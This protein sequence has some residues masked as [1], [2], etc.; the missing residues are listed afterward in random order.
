[1]AVKLGFPVA[2]VEA[3]LRSFD[4]TMPE[5][6]NRLLTDAISTWLFVSE[7]SG[8]ANLEREGVD[9]GRVHFVGNVMIDTLM[10]SRARADALGMPARLG[11]QPGEYAVL[12]LH[13]PSNVDD[14]ATLAALLE[15]ILELASRIPVVF[16]VHPRTAAMLD[17]LGV[18]ERVGLRRL[19]PQGY[20]EFLGLLAAARLVVTDSGGIQEETTVLGVPCVTL[21]ENTERPVTITEGTNRLAGVSPDAVRRALADAQTQP[22][23]AYAPELWDGAAAARV[24]ALLAQD[25]AP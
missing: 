1:V 10:R 3:G 6:I 18:G 20:L 16:P 4:R 17:R 9:P 25:L 5:E 13:R 22:R 2:H 21:R 23:R 15:P 8:L 19:E 12:T 11:L 24:V 14:P 7:R